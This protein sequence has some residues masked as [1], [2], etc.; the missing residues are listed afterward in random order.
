M[1]GSRGGKVGEGELDG[2]VKKYQLPVVRTAVVRYH[3]INK[4]STAVYCI[5]KLLRD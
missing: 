3:V 4:M 2:G 1:C 5:G